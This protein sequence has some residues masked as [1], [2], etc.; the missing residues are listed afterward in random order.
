MS[1]VQ[2]VIVGGGACGVVAA[3]A[4]RS[5]GAD[6]L[7][8]ESD[9]L[10]S[11]STALSSGFIPAPATRIQRQLGIVDS[12][13]MFYEDIQ[14][15][16]KGS[17]DPLLASLFCREIAGIIDWLVDDHG[18]E[19]EVL[20]GFLYPGHSQARMHTV[21][22][23][24]GTALLN[25]LWRAAEKCD[26]T[27]LNNACVAELLL[28]RGTNSIGEQNGKPNGKQRG[29][30]S[31]RLI[32]ISYRRPNGATE[33][34]FADQI[35][36]ACNGFG[37]NP[38]MVREFIPEMSDALYFGHAGNRGDAVLWG[39]A[40]DLQLADMAAYQGHGSVAH[41]HGV[42][43]TWAIIMQGGVQ[44]DRFGRRFWDES[45]GYSEAALAVLAQDGGI[46]WN[47]YDERVHQMALQFPDYQTA[48]QAGAIKT[49][50][51]SFELARLLEIDPANLD[52]E[53]AQMTRAAGDRAVNRVDDRA[54]DRFGRRFQPAHRLHAPFYAVRVTGALFHTQGGLA[55]DE[56]MRVKRLNGA[57]IDNLYAAGGAARGVSGNAASG[58]LSGNGLLAAIA[59]GY[60]AGFAAGKAAIEQVADSPPTRPPPAN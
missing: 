3:L 23:R 21:P 57:V 12:A 18:L 32:G 9:A 60:V 47:L 26:I 58:Y 40:L 7:V 34:V 52:D 27:L 11:G 42:L 30:Q 59:G 25:R 13:Q 38:A 22:E 31:G 48:L 24:S 37:G 29:H 43:I 50:P 19:F 46:A 44:L 54:V 14:A 55:V 17:A 51:S 10:A 1:R 39:R 45:Q 28:E 20:A 8:L 33:S 5:Q 15:K 49:A 36:L 4:A 56:S 53:L 6:L 41:P 2:V 35:V 16:A